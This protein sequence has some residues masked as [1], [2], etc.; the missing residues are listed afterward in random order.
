MRSQPCHEGG[1]TEEAASSIS[2][3]SLANASVIGSEDVGDAATIM[4]ADPLGR[5]CTDTVLLRADPA[6]WRECLGRGI[7]NGRSCGRGPLVAVCPRDERLSQ[8][9][10]RVEPL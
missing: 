5:P 10:Q 4:S 9:E 7:T 2:F 8:S 6:T 1:G 3:P